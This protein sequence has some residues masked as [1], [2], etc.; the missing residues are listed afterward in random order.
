M[1]I[2]S[3]ILGF[4]RLSIKFQTKLKK[5]QDIVQVYQVLFTLVKKL[6]LSSKALTYVKYNK[7]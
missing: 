3:I 5:N 1:N 2:E 7:N 6:R 4:E